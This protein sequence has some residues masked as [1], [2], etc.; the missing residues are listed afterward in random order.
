MTIRLPQ[1]CSMRHCLRIRGYFVMLLIAEVDPSTLQWLDYFFHHLHLLRC[2]S[3]LDE[4]L[5]ETIG[6]LYSL[7][8]RP[9]TYKSLSYWRHAWAV[10]RMQGYNGHVGRQMFLKG[11]TFR[12]FDRSLP[13]NDGSYFRCCECFQSCESFQPGAEVHEAYKSHTLRPLGR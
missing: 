13:R 6:L 5:R 12:R 8:L 1:E 9:L 7:W 2:T 11:F 4:Y 10:E 3:M